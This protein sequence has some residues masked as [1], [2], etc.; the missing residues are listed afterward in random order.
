V[1]RDYTAAPSRPLTAL[2]GAAYPARVI[3]FVVQP[4]AAESRSLLL[5]LLATP[6]HEL[7]L[8]ALV[9]S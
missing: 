4:E 8:I 9:S 5:F 1:L 7:I 2:V 6:A 3:L